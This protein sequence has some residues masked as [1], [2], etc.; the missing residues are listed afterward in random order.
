MSSGGEQSTEE[1]KYGIPVMVT[2]SMQR[3]E[4]EGFT[5]F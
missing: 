5:S 1:K 4:A 3:V 2:K